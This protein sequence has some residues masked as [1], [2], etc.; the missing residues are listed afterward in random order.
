MQ[1]L[2][3]NAISD[4]KLCTMK[5]KNTNAKI[6][7]NKPHLILKWRTTLIE[8]H[9]P[10]IPHLII[11]FQRDQRDCKVFHHRK[12]YSSSS[13]LLQGDGNKKRVLII[14]VMQHQ[15]SNLT[16]AI[17][18]NYYLRRNSIV[19]KATANSSK[20]HHQ[21]K[22]QHSHSILYNSISVKRIL[23]IKPHREYKHSSSAEES[24]ATSKE[25]LLRFLPL[26]KAH[27]NPTV[28]ARDTVN[29]PSRR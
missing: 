9:F 16:L 3:Y 4:P 8:K 19:M 2:H 23:Y 11:L 20:S 21:N 7:L 28:N 1:E 29:R 13:I 26:V 6:L 5:K 25:A 15:L 24:N 27:V 18:D 12:C 22:R 17:N 14:S 10:N